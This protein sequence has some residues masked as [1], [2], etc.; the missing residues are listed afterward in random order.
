M[1]CASCAASITKSL[2]KQGMSQIKVNHINGNVSFETVEESNIETAA[3]AVESLGY[4][5][6]S[7]K[8]ETHHDH[9]HSG[10]GIDKNLL[11]FITCL[12]FTLL[13]MGH[14]GCPGCGCII[15]MYSWHLRFRC[16]F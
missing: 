10:K 16:T 8:K 9:D 6:N 2:Q 14:S 7:G 11:Y 12:P 5:V 1:D 15:P 3:K 13:L 4:T